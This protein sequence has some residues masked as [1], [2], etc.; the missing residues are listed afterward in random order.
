M[1]ANEHDIDLSIGSKA[2]S[3]GTSIITLS[4]EAELEFQRKMW[5]ALAPYEAIESN[6]STSSEEVGNFQPRDTLNKATVGRNSSK[7][8]V[9]CE[10]EETSNGDAKRGKTDDINLK[11][12]Y[13]QPIPKKH[14]KYCTKHP[15][16]VI[17]HL[18]KWFDEN[19]SHPYPTAEEKK[20]LALT[21]GLTLAQIS[22]W[23]YGE[24]IRRS[25]NALSYLNRWYSEHGSYECLTKEE[26]AELTSATRITENQIKHWF[27]YIKPRRLGTDANI[28]CKRDRQRGG[29]LTQYAVDILE[30]WYCNHGSY[31]T[32]EQ[33]E[34]LAS[35][36]MLPFCRVD[37]WFENRRQKAWK[38]EIIQKAKRKER[39]HASKI[40]Y[41]FTMSGNKARKLEGITTCYLC[42][43]CQDM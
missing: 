38:E 19:K 37:K 41:G 27:S 31:P 24:R 2:N 29:S 23:F 11:D 9:E 42:S 17:D 25:Q 3:I 39:E 13:T 36:T 8:N 35:A 33:K 22:S 30:K 10:P 4:D 6:V 15:Q 32:S 1:P 18:E 12:D 34:E 16:S 26:K 14:S 21:T 40:V 7:K 43:E 28:F 20:E 5:L